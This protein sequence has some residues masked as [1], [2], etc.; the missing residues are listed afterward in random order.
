MAKWRQ[1]GELQRREASDSLW[2]TNA[3]RE[4]L[5]SDAEHGKVLEAK[6]SA[7]MVAWR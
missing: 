5:L 4:S 7:A 6:R 3:K 2:S 1:P